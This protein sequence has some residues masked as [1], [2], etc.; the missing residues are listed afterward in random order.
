MGTGPERRRT[1]TTGRSMPARWTASSRLR[2]SSSAARRA[3]SFAL[4]SSCPAKR[5]NGRLECSN[6]AGHRSPQAA[7]NQCGPCWSLPVCTGG[8]SASGL[9][10]RQLVSR[11]RLR[12]IRHAP[13]I[14]THSDSPV[15]RLAPPPEIPTNA[16]VNARPMSHLCRRKSG[17]AHSRGK[18]DATTRERPRFL[19]SRGAC[20]GWVVAYP[21]AAMR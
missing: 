4:D 18:R 9:G 8:K 1:F 6:S 15:R 21:R 20:A 5:T 14:P 7:Q 3:A 12:P 19:H 10:W 11:Q 2:T 17:L 16:A 13:P